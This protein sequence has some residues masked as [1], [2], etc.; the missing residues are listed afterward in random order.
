MLTKI[1]QTNSLASISTFMLVEGREYDNIIQVGPCH[2]VCDQAL[3][4]IVISS[5]DPWVLVC[6]SFFY[7]ILLCVF[8]H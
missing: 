5:V 4:C 3:V 2:I 7:I 1:S 6:G 8:I